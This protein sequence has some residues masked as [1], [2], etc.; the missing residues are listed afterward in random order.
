MDPLF[1]ELFHHSSKDHAKGHP[2]FSNQNPE[3]W[4]R[5]WKVVKYKNYPR[6][7]KI[8]LSSKLPDPSDLFKTI[9]S[10]SSER[11]FSRESISIDELSILLRYSCGMKDDTSSL[12]IQPSAG[13]MYPLEIYPLLFRDTS[14][15]SS[16]IY[17]YAPKKKAL[18]VLWEHSFSSE[19]IDSLA[20][21]PW[22]KNAAICFVI[23]AIF[24]RAQ[25][26]YGE[27]GYRHVL[28]EAGHVGQNMSLVASALGLKSCPLSGTQDTAI[29]KLLDI[30]G[31]TESVVYAVTVG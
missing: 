8:T 27:R 21:Y 17:H 3:K 20:I 24:D 15:I 13:S 18:E 11:N 9:M 6:L 25:N 16:G 19:E 14:E 31:T 29:E 30:D 4:P 23:T 2:P 1:S 22:V 28:L 26:K 5:S 10:R 12:R 7:P